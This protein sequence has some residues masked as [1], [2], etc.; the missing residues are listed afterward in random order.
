V[1]ASVVAA[2]R[3]W[4]SGSVI[5]VQGLSCSVQCGILPDQGSNSCAKNWQADSSPLSHQ[6][7]PNNFFSFA[8]HVSLV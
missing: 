1:W 7:I 5:L 3:L 8:I 4:S 6:G 2:P